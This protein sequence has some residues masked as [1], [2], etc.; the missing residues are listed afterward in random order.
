MKNG[1]KHFAFEK[2]NRVFK[3]WIIGIAIILLAISSQIG[4]A[5]DF[6]KRFAFEHYNQELLQV[7]Q[8]ANIYIVNLTI[9]LDI[10]ITKIDRFGN[11]LWSK[12]YGNPP[13][14]EAIY[15]ILIGP[16]DNLYLCGFQDGIGS[17]I[18]GLI[19][20]IDSSGNQVF[21]KLLGLATEFTACENVIW[22][23]EGFTLAAH[24]TDRDTSAGTKLIK[25]DWHGNIV[26]EEIVSL[27]GLNIY[28]LDSISYLL[29]GQGGLLIV[30]SSFQIVSYF[31]GIQISG[32]GRY[33]KFVR[34]LNGILYGLHINS[35]IPFDSSFI[36]QRQ[37]K[38]GIAPDSFPGYL[39]DMHQIVSDSTWL[40]VGI[41]HHDNFSPPINIDHVV[42][43]H[44]D[45]NFVPLRTVC[46][47]SDLY[48][49][50]PSAG[51]FF[52]KSSI[53]GDRMYFGASAKYDTLRSRANQFRILSF[54]TS[55]AGLCN[56]S[57][58]VSYTITKYPQ[59][60]V[61]S[62]NF[63]YFVPC[64]TFVQ[65]VVLQQRGE[66]LSTGDCSDLTVGIKEESTGLDNMNIFPNPFSDYLFFSS[67]DHG[68]LIIYD[69]IGKVIFR[70]HI[71][72]GQEE[73]NLKFLG[74][75]IYSLKFES[76]KGVLTKRIIKISR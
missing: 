41:H 62:T 13:T 46:L 64:S 33:V 5:Q 51:Q 31:I 15:D 71:K 22:D 6:D 39:Y 58:T 42:I 36:P 53:L 25:F 17:E 44:T 12:S 35:I 1:Y 63:T 23:E 18:K 8:W 3:R 70:K 49:E 38:Y 27:I 48:L 37:I 61:P 66:Y 73:L 45:Q 75:G 24:Y 19:L 47:Y 60:H 67:I 26:N 54:D 68:L 55:L 57:D 56:L 43:Y 32:G 76:E 74:E 16:N 20:S 69:Q 40:I 10:N 30:D 52:S 11:L 50:N 59:Y 14:R 7:D 29:Y 21:C 9:N 72:E 28:E 34:G 2:F 65:D 4:L